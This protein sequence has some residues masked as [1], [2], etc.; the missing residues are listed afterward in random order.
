M[1]V[2]APGAME[3]MVAEFEEKG[4]VV[5]PNMFSADEIEEMRSEADYIAGVS[6]NAVRFSSHHAAALTPVRAP[7]THA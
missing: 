7:D 6:L 4:V 2:A 5:V 1:V 3:D